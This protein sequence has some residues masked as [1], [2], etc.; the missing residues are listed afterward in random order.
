MGEYKKLKK[1]I[2][3]LGITCLLSG[4]FLFAHTNNVAAFDMTGGFGGMFGGL[5]ANRIKIS[6]N[7]SYSY[8][9]PEGIQAYVMCQAGDSDAKRPVAGG[10]GT[11]VCAA[12]P[13]SRNFTIINTSPISRTVQFKG[14]GKSQSVSME[15]PIKQMVR[16]STG[17]KVV[18]Y[19]NASIQITIHIKVPK[20][21]TATIG[22]NDGGVDASDAIEVER[23]TDTSDSNSK[24][25]ITPEDKKAMDNFYKT[26]TDDT[27]FCP[28]SND[29]GTPNPGVPGGNQGDPSG[30]DG[31][32]GIDGKG[33]T[34]GID[35]KDG[36]NGLN[37]DVPDYRPN[38]NNNNYK[39]LLRDLLNYNHK[40]TDPYNAGDID[41]MN[42]KGG[43]TGDSNLDNWF[44]GTGDGNAVTD[45]M[46][47]DNTGI[48]GLLNGDGSD[49]GDNSTYTPNPDYDGVTLDYGGENK[50]NGN[51][52]G[53]GGFLNMDDLGS[54]FQ[55]GLDDLNGLNGD[56]SG[57]L[58]AI[59]PKETKG[60][61]GDKLRELLDDG[62]HN[63]PRGTAN[64]QELYEIAKKWLLANGFS[65]NDIVNGRNYDPNSAY[66]E[67]TTAWDM[68]RITTLLKG[69]RI[70]LTSPT[71]VKNKDTKS[72]SKTAKDKKYSATHN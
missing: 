28:E 15:I 8:I 47:T 21:S 43:D 34:S 22:Q 46:T 36:K 11:Y 49:A 37:T 40:N 64:D 51:N 4:S 2:A 67:P 39:D 45:D 71:D 48:D 53:L 9:T 23:R 6:K 68:N 32:N 16:S 50:D 52:G 72:L 17:D 55:N 54:R 65:M 12:R 20:D 63:N 10:E 3:T 62:I 30:R 69:K 59:S 61:L 60:S 27:W 56:N 29:P 70:T 25:A 7:V 41:W 18:G 1:A 19:E 31:K 26:C 5:G 44:G 14:A 33:G 24:Q 35:G 38:T 57:L 13:I 58:G 42:S 66:T